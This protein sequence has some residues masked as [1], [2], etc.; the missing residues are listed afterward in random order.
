MLLSVSIF[1]SFLLKIGKHDTRNLNKVVR[2]SGDLDRKKGRGRNS[3]P[4]V[5]VCT[6]SQRRT[7]SEAKNLHK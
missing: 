2:K 7:V 6:Q 4:F 1:H 5:C 3:C